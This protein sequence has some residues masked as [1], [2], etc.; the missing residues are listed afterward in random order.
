M[1]SLSRIID[2]HSHPILPFGEPAPVGAKQPDWSAE[3]AISY[4]EEYRISAC[5]LSAPDSANYTTGQPERHRSI[6]RICDTVSSN[7]GL[8]KEVW[9]DS[10]RTAPQAVTP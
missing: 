8:P 5:V 3:S 6:Q 9:N 2:V 1:A 7:D 4:M 10:K